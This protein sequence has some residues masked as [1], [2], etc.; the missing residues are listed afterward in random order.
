MSHL[1]EVKNLGKTYRP[2][3]AWPWSQKSVAIEPISFHI[4]AGETLAVMGETGSGKS[5]LAK[6]IAGVDN[7]SSGELW[8]NGQK[9]HNQHYQQRY[10][11]G[12]GK[13]GAAGVGGCCGTD[14]SFTRALRQAL[15]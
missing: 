1:L 3:K 4:D 6:I 13:Q 2:R 11:A 10:Q 15:G 5:T 7:P 9:L 12:D 8:L 14:A